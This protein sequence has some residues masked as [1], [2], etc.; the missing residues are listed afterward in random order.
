M[1]SV[2]T[3][4]KMYRGTVPM[5]TKGP[6]VTFLGGEQL[7]EEVSDGPPSKMLVIFAVSSLLFQVVLLLFKLIHSR[8]ITNYA[9]FLRATLVNSVLNIYGF[10]IIIII[11]IVVC[12]YAVLHYLSIK[13]HE[14]KDEGEADQ[15]PPLLLIIYLFYL[16]FVSLPYLQNFHLR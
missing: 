1:S 4:W 3:C 12:C 6:A 11:T 8:K 5:L 2:L 16:I 7:L 15:M 10:L 9:V 13:H 14:E